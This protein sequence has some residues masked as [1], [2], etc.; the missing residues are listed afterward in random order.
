MPDLPTITLSQ[1]HFDRVVAAFP[2]DTTAKKI[3]AYRAWTVNNLIDFVEMVEVQAAR[4]A[5]A[6]QV[7]QKQAEILASLPPRLAFPPW[8]TTP[9]EPVIVPRG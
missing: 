2:G 5:A 6:V 7:T 4:D 8:G 3:A 1:A 9:D